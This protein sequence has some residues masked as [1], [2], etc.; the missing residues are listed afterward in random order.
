MSVIQAYKDAFL[1]CY[2]QK[3]IEVKINRGRRGEEPRFRVW[4]DSDPGEQ[5]YTEADL[6]EA[7]RNFLRGKM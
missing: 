2:P 7:T 4:I 3:K 6:R 5:T 1:T